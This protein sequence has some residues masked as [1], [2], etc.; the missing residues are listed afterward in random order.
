MAGLTS[1]GMSGRNNASVGAQFFRRVE[2]LDLIDLASNHC[3]ERCSDPWH[4]EQVLMHRLVLNSAAMRFSC[5]FICCAMRSC[6]ASCSRKSVASG[7]GSSNRRRK[8]RPRTP[9]DVAALRQ[10]EFSLPVQ[11]RVHTVAQH[12]ARNRAQVESLAQQVLAR[13]CLAP[14]H[15]RPCDQVAA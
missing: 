8:P 14:R 7:S 9:K 10:L 11:E 1:A 2:A 5:A 4:T 3:G 13:P 15:M 6:K 12:R